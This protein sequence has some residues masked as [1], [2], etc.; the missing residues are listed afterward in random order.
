LPF[1]RARAEAAEPPTPSPNAEILAFAPTPRPPIPTIPDE[2]GYT[3]HPGA[4]TALVGADKV[5]LRA[6]IR[7]NGAQ[8]M[9]L[10]ARL[11]VVADRIANH[12]D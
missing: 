1:V 2:R 6:A 9:P 4:I 11:K 3:G 5:V 12:R 7:A 10:V 8:I